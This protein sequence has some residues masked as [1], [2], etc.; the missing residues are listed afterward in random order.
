MVNRDDLAAPEQSVDQSAPTLDYYVIALSV[1]ML[2]LGLRQWA[3]IVGV[4]DGGGGGSFE[5]MS[6]AWKFA[7]MHMAVVDSVAAVGLWMRVAWGKVIW[8]YAVV[9]EIAIHTVFIATFGGN[10]LLVVFHLAAFTG[11][12]VL[13][14]MTRRKP[15]E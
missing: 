4:L 13:A 1:A 7:T 10:L 2:A 12:V 8:V 14:V 6:I 5:T 11:F 9:S 15:V 3:V